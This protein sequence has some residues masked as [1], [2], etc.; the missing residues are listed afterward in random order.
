MAEAF[1]VLIP[2]LNP[3]EAEARIVNLPIQDG[4]Q[5]KTGNLLC[6]LETTKSAA[7][8]PAEKNGYVAGL[9]FQQGEIAKA[10]EL[11]CYLAPSPD[12]IPPQAPAPTSQAGADL[13]SGLRITQPALALAQREQLDSTSLPI[14]PLVTKEMVQEALTTQK[15]PEEPKGPRAALDPTAI[16][17]YGGGGHG[18]A[19]IDLLRAIGEH[20]IVGVIDDSLP[21]D[22]SV[23]GVPLLGNGDEAL[24]ELYEYGIYLAVNA[25]GGIGDISSRVKVF[26]CLTRA[27]FENPTLVHPTAFIEPSATLASGVQVFPHAYVGSEAQVGF[28]AIV[29][30]G[31]IVSHDCVLEDYVNLAPGTILAGAVKVG[32]RTLIGMGVTVNLGVEI[33]AGARIGNGATVKADVPSGGIVR[34]GGIWPE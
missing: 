12:W 19:V 32:E 8:L 11:L 5:V 31:V 22:E 14:G 34:A 7:D 9:R 6:V 16:A 20:R 29:N 30:T 2:L 23:M 13:P 24:P 18:K 4:Q 3:N 1:P 27:G 33:G 28:G 10:G 26:E 15:K 21:K 25:V 17:V